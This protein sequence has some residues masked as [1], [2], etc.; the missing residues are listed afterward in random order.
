MADEQIDLIERLASR[1][2]P[3]VEVRELDGW[4]VRFSAAVARRCNSVLPNG[5][6]TLPLAEKLARVEELYAPTGRPARYQISPANRPAELD[7]VLAQRGYWLECPTFV[8][9]AAL[10]AVLKR[11]GNAAG[12]VECADEPGA[13]WLDTFRVA[14]GFSDS[15][16]VAR[17]EVLRRIA[18]RP[19]YALVREDGQPVAVGLAVIEQGWVGLFCM[20]T[21]PAARRRGH[22]RAVLAGLVRW[23]LA[24]G[25]RHAYLQVTAENEAARPLYEGLG[26]TTRY[27]YHYRTK[28]LGPIED[29]R[30]S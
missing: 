6:G 28:S 2:W 24:G 26:F 5:G 1:A 8:Q 27:S 3:A 22:A 15:E 29:R 20:A 9:V 12:E 16:V 11:L 14:E 13:D 10:G 30:T 21:V 23:G 18:G 7:E 4:Q 25:A 19:V 17:Q